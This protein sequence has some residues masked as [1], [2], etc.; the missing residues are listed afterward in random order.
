MLQ[1]ITPNP[2][3]PAEEGMC[4]QYVRQTFGLPIRY[5]SA[6]EAWNNS[7]SQHTGRDFPQGVDHPVWYGLASNANGH[8]VLRM[9]DGSVY[10]TSDL[11]P[12]PLHH[13]PSL[14]DLEAYY[15]HYGVPLTYRGWTEDVAGFPVITTEGISYEGSITPAEEDPF[16]ANASEAQLERLVDAADRIMG[17]ITDPTARVLTTNDLDAIALAILKRECD[18]IDPTAKT[19]NVE[20][21][22]KTTLAKRINW[23]PYNFEQARQDSAELSAKV[24][25]LIELLTKAGK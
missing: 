8:V 9:S 14:A 17:V 6:T 25:T 5:G 16:M 11:A 13:H 22:K 21:V 4:L 12:S 7:P 2:H 3:I 18:L 23:M 1:I 20:P 15:A 10:S 19:Q 24:D